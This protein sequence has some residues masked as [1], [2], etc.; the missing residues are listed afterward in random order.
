MEHMHPLQVFDN[1]FTLQTRHE[2]LEEELFV[3]HTFE[4]CAVTLAAAALAGVSY[5]ASFGVAV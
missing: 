4:I 2:M 5:A 3:G 1:R